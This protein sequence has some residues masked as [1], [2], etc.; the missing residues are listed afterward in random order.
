MTD[1]SNFYRNEME[2][3]AVV[4]GFEDCTMPD[5]AFD[6]PSHLVVALFYLHRARLTVPEAATRMRASL[7]RF[8]DHHGHDRRKYNETITLFWIKLVR[9]FL[10]KTDTARTAANIASEMVAS[11]GN[12]KIIYDYYSKEWLMSEEARRA[13]VEPDIKPLDF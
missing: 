7:Y 8:L 3:E 6:H 2:I 1:S 9:G 12:S 4:R 10:N 11:F 5:A 13:W